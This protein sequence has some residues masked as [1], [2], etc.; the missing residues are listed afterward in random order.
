ML[1]TQINSNI[2]FQIQL[3]KNIQHI[4]VSKHENMEVLKYESISLSKYH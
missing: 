4:Q 1:N 2:W 3:F